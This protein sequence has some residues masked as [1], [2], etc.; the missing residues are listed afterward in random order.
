M[1]ERSRLSWIALLAVSVVVFVLHKVLVHHAVWADEN[2]HQYVA[3]RVAE[4]ASLYGEVRSARPPL[5]IWI[6]ALL[7]GLGLSPFLA[8][9]LVAASAALVVAGLLFDTGR[10]LLHEH[11][12]LWCAVLFLV[13]PAVAGR[14]AYT[15]ISLVALGC[16]ACLWA[17]VRG[18]G[19]LAG[20]LGGLGLLAG[21]HA[22]VIVGVCGLWSLLGGWGRAIRFLSG[23]LLVL[24][25]G[26]SVAWFLGG[27][28]VWEDLV[29]HHLYHLGGDGR[30]SPDLGWWLVVWAQENFTLLS[31]A[32]VALQI[33]TGEGC[34]VKPRAW[35]P[36]PRWL[37]AGVIVSQVV[38][39]IGMEGGLALYLYP[40]VPPLA[41]LA[42]LGLARLSLRWDP[43]GQ[44]EERRG[45]AI[46]LA[47][48]V[49]GGT[50][51]AWSAV[52]E[53]Y[54][55]RDERGYPLLPWLRAQSMAR[56]AEPRIVGEI[57]ARLEE[58]EDGKPIFGYP[59]LS[60]L[61]ALESGR[62]IAADRVDFAPRWFEQGTLDRATLMRE[63]EDAGVGWFVSPNMFFLRDSFFEG[64]LRAC[65]EEPEVFQRLPG[66]GIPRIFLFERKGTGNACVS[67]LH[68]HGV[69]D[70]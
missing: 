53:R 47:L 24:G 39:V 46:P 59:T 22:L 6:P 60:G 44:Y 57:A 28:H 10:R 32:L 61:V 25:A 58:A 1:R 23:I 49:V 27:V 9:R 64:W 66:S 26:V 2:L 5:T 13:S 55:S 14:N 45:L 35:P 34:H 48:V 38:V 36:D 41:L 7:V 50:L 68:D 67:W 65:F 42:G 70:E 43:D 69:L 12:G 30:G 17:T 51:C 4:G 3:F 52:S 40:A 33:P 18:R 21:Q 29:V 8:V 20:G 54:G 62:S 11:A 19:L 56:V 63:V 31:L 16:M 37:V 15:G